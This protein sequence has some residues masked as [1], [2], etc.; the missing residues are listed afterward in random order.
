M[1]T[2]A[3]IFRILAAGMFGGAVVLL[4]MAAWNLIQRQRA[5][6][7]GGSLTSMRRAEMRQLAL[8]G[9]PVFRFFLPFVSGL[10]ATVNRLGLDPLRQYVHGPYVRAGYPGG[11]DDDEVVA[12]GVLM[13]VA[14]TIDDG[15]LTVALFGPAFAWVALRGDSAGVCGDGVAP[16]VAGGRA[17]GGDFA[18]AAL[19]A[20]F[21]GADAAVGHVDADRAVAGD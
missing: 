6:R 16:E 18:G 3:L 7:A 19:C 14:F 1:V 11:L 8:E 15:F 10:S 12:A 2:T 5:V 20:G 21:A 4:A 13:S 17:A 9:S